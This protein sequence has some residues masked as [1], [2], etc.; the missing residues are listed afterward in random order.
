MKKA[1][2][3]ERALALGC[4]YEQMEARFLIGMD[5]LKV[6]LYCAQDR[7]RRKRDFA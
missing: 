4:D 1:R 7:S 5:Y 6:F 3:S 2:H